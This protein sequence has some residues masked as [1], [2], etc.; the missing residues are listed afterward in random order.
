MWQLSEKSYPRGDA[1][2]LGQIDERATLRSLADDQQLRV[3]DLR[4]RADDDVVC[5]ARDEMSDGQQR[6]TPQ[7][8]TPTRR[9]P[10]ARL[11]QIQVDAIT[12]HADVLRGDADLDETIL[13]GLADADHASRSS[14]CPSDH[15]ARKRVVGEQI[16][17]RPP[18]GDDDRL[19]ELGAEEDCRHAIGIEIMCVDQ[20]ELESRAEDRVQRSARAEIEK[21]RCDMH[22]DARNDRVAGVERGDPRIAR[23][24]TETVVGEGKPRHRGDD[25]GDDRPGF[26]QAPQSGLDKDAVRGL[27]GIW[28]QRREGQGSDAGNG[29]GSRTWCRRTL[30]GVDDGPR[31]QTPNHVARQLAAG[32]S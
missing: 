22:A 7:I 26:G 11:K 17:V 4:Q 9:P 29:L 27:D 15:A 32:L 12:Q 19:A 6:R 5:L 10:V 8:V 13:Q 2:P 20:I 16:D 21:P 1:C 14:R 31:F 24:V 25:P 30:R 18:R 3:G 23:I 28:E